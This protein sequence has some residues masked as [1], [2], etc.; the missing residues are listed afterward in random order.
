MLSR[1]ME[2]GLIVVTALL[3][4]GCAGMGR[5]TKQYS[6]QREHAMITEKGDIQWKPEPFVYEPGES[7]RY[8]DFEAGEDSAEGTSPETAWKHHPWDPNAT[9]KAAAA[10][11]IDTYVFKGGV[12]YRGV[13]IADESGKTG[14]P[15]RLTFD[16]EWGETQPLILGSEQVTGWQK[17]SAD[18]APPDMPQ[19]EEVWYAD[20]GTDYTPRAMWMVQESQ[21]RRV[22]LARE[23]DWEVTNPDDVKSNWYEWEGREKETITEGGSEQVKVWGIDSRHLTAD[24]PDAYQGATVWSEYAGVMGTPYANAVEAYDPE[25]HAIRFAGPWADASARSPIQH[26]RYFLDNHPRFLDTAGE[27]YYASEGPVAG[28][29]FVRLPE[30]VTPEDVV[31]E[32]ARHTTLID[33]KDQSHIHVSGLA[34]QFQN[35]AHWYDRWWQIAE[36]DPS[37]VKARGTCRDIRVS[38]CRFHHVAQAVWMLTQDADDVMD[39]LAVT[40]CDI[41]ETDY[42]PI[43]IRRGP[44]EMHRVEVLRNRLH[45]VGL[46]PM[47]SEHGHAVVVSFADVSEIAGNVLDRCWGAGLFIFGGKGSGD[48]RMVPMSRVLIHHN[49][50]TNTLLNTNDWGGIESWQG[51]PTYIFNN[52][53]G[54]P[55]GYW[56]WSHVMRG[57]TAEERSHTTARFGFA[58]YLD[59][60]FKQYVFNNIA[61]GNS[62][63]LTSPLCNSAGLQGLIGFLNSFFNN[64]LYKF[65]AGSRRQAPQAGRNLYLGN[66]WVEMGEFYLRHSGPREAAPEPNARDAAAGGSAEEPFDYDTLGY[67]N[68]VFHGDPRDFAVFEHTGWVYDTLDGLRIALE[69]RQALVTSVGLNAETMPLRDPENKDFRPA[70]GYDGVGGGV[71]FFVPWSLYGTVGEWHFY[72]HPADVSRILGEHF[73]MTPAHAGRGMYRLLPRHDLTAH[74]VDEDD[75]VEGVLEDWTEG[76]LILNGEDEFCMLADEELKSDIVW[77]ENTYPGEQRETPDMG[78][79]SFLVEAVLKVAAGDEGILVSKANSDGYVLEVTA[80]G[81]ARMSLRVA[82][83]SICSRSSTE[84]IADG[85]WHHILAEVDRAASRG[86]NLYVDGRLSNGSWTGLMPSRA[87]SLSNTGDLLVGRGPEG[88]YLACTL[89]FLRIS[90]GTLTDAFTT[91]EE[92]HEWQF[93]GP[94]LK[95]FFGNAPV[96]KR[97]AGAIELPQ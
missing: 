81:R 67:A 54:N 29:I 58:Y 94:F 38:N 43:W 91:I 70:P 11:G 80:D 16:P 60:A 2:A 78:T 73:Y 75:F 52:I 21:I 14:A 48:R 31:L 3:L 87:Q 82:G 10:R 42:G 20:I 69:D 8:I 49:K 9:D 44:G 89:D 63:D 83:L 86:L 76:A 23:P 47:R 95:D 7:I 39:E 26:C 40:D 30:G 46:R 96:G 84:R 64:T 88:G 33:I 36:E 74:G 57:K 92:L 6:W 32:V 56:H 37:C 66:V 97:D 55:G 4:A 71:K 61:W 59:G 12:A 13:L 27:Y 34:F 72:K 28:R 79:N 85:R 5:E 50:A 18:Q 25:R 19:P 41:R 24:S 51:G 45:R 17:L 62:N 68:N 90:Q 65:G 93:N 22:H 53:S 35:V 77:G 1:R 15:I